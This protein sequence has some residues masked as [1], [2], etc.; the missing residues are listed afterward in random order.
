MVI[1]TH[2]GIVLSSFLV[3]T[4]TSITEVG[5]ML[6]LLIRAVSRG[7]TPLVSMAL[8]TVGGGLEDERAVLVGR[9]R[10]ELEDG[11]LLLLLLL[12]VISEDFGRPSAG[13]ALLLLEGTS[14]VFGR[15]RAGGA[16]VVRIRL[17]LLGTAI[18][19]GGI[20]AVLLLVPIEVDVLVLTSSLLLL[21]LMTAALVEVEADVRV[22]VSP[23][24]LWMV[25][26]T[27][28]VTVDFGPDPA[29]EDTAAAEELGSGEYFSGESSA[30]VSARP[31]LTLISNNGMN[32]NDFFIIWVSAQVNDPSILKGTT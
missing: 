12:L 16:E 32:P 5:G 2:I 30:M 1:R 31:A 29:D 14:E 11:T 13:G 3:N 23:G 4:L 20:L 6:L 7:R 28:E 26:T 19:I 10:S 21:L 24:Q 15:A 8:A 27:V 9:A 25:V 18:S 17:E 22:I